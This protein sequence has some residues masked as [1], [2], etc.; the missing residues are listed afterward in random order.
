MSSRAFGLLK[1]VVMVSFFLHLTGCDTVKDWLTTSTA[2]QLASFDQSMAQH[3][4]LQTRLQLNLDD[5]L[6]AKLAATQEISAKF[7]DNMTFAISEAKRLE[8]HD[9]LQALI[10]YRDEFL[11]LQSFEISRLENWSVIATD[12]CAK[13]FRA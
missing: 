1:I 4:Q 9:L 10:F 2:K 5:D 11:T 3:E 7:K 8:M 12:S 6:S 13:F